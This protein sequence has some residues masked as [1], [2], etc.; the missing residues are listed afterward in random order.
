[1]AG[2]ER[3]IQANMGIFYFLVFFA[4][5]GFFPLLGIYLR[6]NVGLSGSKI[7]LILSIGPIVMV[8]AQPL[9]GMICDYT[10]RSRLVLTLTLLATGL[11]GLLFLFGGYY[12][13]LFVAALLAVFQSAIIPISDGMIMGVAT[14]KKWNY[15]NFRLWG[16]VGFAVATFV[17]GLTSDYLGLTVIFYVFTVMLWLASLSAWKLPEENVSIAVDLRSGLRQL[18]RLPRFVLF[19][20]ATFLIFGPIQANNVFFGLLF[21]DLGG[22]VTGVGIGF[23]LAAGSEVP[24]MKYAA[25]W[26]RSWGAF[27]IL[28]LAAGVSGVRW[29]FYFF[30]PPLAGVYIS[31]LTQ[32]ISV[33]LFIPAALQYVQEVA[34]KAVRVTA[35]SMYTAVGVGLGNWFFTFVGGLI[36]DRFHIFGA[37]LFFALLTFGGVG[38]L[39]AIMRLE[40]GKG[41]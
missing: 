20:L 33:G 35:I 11:V 6:E 7:G 37:Y 36:M 24:F 13:L 38:I 14:Q 28:L 15:G 26:M 41:S 1:M 21:Q 31:T 17:M 12:W 16:A 22:T 40:Y 3:R 2:S 5:G 23:L 30:E 4:L 8:V 34:P 18:L 32:G 27:P 29:L 25:P 39:V 9:W 19:L 10:Q